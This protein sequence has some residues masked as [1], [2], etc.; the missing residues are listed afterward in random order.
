MKP[1]AV[2]LWETS[3]T[4]VKMDQ[5]HPGCNATATHGCRQSHTF[6]PL[7]FAAVS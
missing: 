5:I 1:E 6:G 2:V 3:A 7:C 4:E